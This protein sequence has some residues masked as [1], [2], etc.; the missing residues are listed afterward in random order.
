MQSNRITSGLLKLNHTSGTDKIMRLL[1]AKAV[2]FKAKPSRE[3]ISSILG[4]HFQK[5]YP[6]FNFVK[7]HFENPVGTRLHANSD[8]CCITK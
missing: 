2:F 3:L 6:T 4:V 1:T 5:L 7:P 8:I